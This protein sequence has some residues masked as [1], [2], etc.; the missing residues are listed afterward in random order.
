MKF[1][2][3]TQAYGYSAIAHRVYLAHT[4]PIDD[5]W[6]RFLRRLG[7]GFLEIQGVKKGVIERVPSTYFN[8]NEANLLEFL[9]SLRIFKCCICGV[10]TFRWDSI[11][12]IEGSSYFRIKRRA[13]IDLHRIDDTGP[14]ERK[15]PRVHEIRRYICRNCLD[16]FFFEKGRAKF[17]SLEEEWSEDED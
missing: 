17:E 12:E 4:A 14:Y 9:T 1:S 15:V 2:D 6:E 16:D 7:L 13:Q 5:E 3:V 10:Y 11:G 8:P